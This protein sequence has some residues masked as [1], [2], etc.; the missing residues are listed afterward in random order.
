MEEKSFT[1][2]MQK[3]FDKPRTKRAAKAVNLVK[4]FL[5]KNFR[6][7]EKQI[8]LSNKINELLW[9]KGIEHAPRRIEIKAIL[10]DGV[11]RAFLKGEKIEKIEKK[12]EEKKEVK[13]KE[14]EEA[15]KKGVEKIAEKDIEQKKKDKK[16]KER[17]VE[18]S[19]IKRGTQ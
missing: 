18:K 7:N 15:A 1:V 6:T 4:R 2:P 17:A 13:E 10:E 9:S 14:A 8:K 12:E 19:A 5:K 3:V 16:A 11:V